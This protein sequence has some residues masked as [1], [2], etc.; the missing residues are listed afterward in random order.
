[1]PDFEALYYKLFA[2]IADATEAIEARNY[3]LAEEILTRIQQE[4]EELVIHE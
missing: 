1:M 2:A 3:G 4:A